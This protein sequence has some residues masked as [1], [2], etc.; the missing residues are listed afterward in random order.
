MEKMVVYNCKEAGIQKDPTD[1]D[2]LDQI[3]GEVKA[4]DTV[5]VD[6]SRVYW[7]WDDRQYYKCVYGTNPEEGYIFTGVVKVV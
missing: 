3:I 2:L 7:S 4:G 1:P 5:L 6:T